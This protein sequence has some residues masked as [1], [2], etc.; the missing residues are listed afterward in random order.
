MV[1]EDRPEVVEQFRELYDLTYPQ[2]M[3]YTLRRARSREDALDAVSETFMVVWRR[4]E[5]MPDAEQAVP[6]VYG[7]ARK[8]LANQYRSQE[9]RTRLARK[10]GQA[11]RTETHEP[12]FEA[13]HQALGTLRPA[14][15]EMLTLS[16]WDDLDNQQ[17]AQILNIGPKKVAVR[18][19][20]ARKRFATQLAKLDDISAAKVS[21]D[22]KQMH[23]NRTQGDV[24]G[25][26]DKGA[27][28][29]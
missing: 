3:A 19:H 22:V 18:L 16:S 20:R 23:D 29:P 26:P 8:I 13:V 9:R 2:I 11:A 7:I 1:Q 5:D 6:W 17:I 12:T 14:D 10:L 25:T 28:K 4:L 21:D 27:E 15:R 24:K